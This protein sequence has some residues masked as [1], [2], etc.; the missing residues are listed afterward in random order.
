[1]TKPRPL[2]L[3]IRRGE[4]ELV[5]LALLL[6][7]SDAARRLPPGTIDDVIA[8]LSDEEEDRRDANRP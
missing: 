7:L 1:M 5:A 8:L 3:A 6:S 4:W 2:T